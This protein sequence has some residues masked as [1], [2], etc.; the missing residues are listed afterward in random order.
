M[1]DVWTSVGV[2]VGVG[3]AS[4]S[5]QEWIDPVVAIFVGLKIGWEGLSIFRR[6]TGGLMDTAIDP[7]ER[8][9]IESI[10]NTTCQNGIE[11]HALRTRQS[12]ARRFISI[13][14]LVPGDWT[15]Q[16]GHDLLENI[17][18]DIRRQINHCSVFTHVE[19]IEDPR[20]FVDQDLIRT[21]T[22]PD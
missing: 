3:I 6:S 17:E 18:N 8:T 20:A 16:Q 4:L 22:L 15:V 12:G 10:L 7:Q 13:H 9:L 21:D 1:S 11:W 19:P 2:V 5:G 14:I